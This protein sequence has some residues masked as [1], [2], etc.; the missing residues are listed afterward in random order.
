[1]GDNVKTATA[2]SPSERGA[3]CRRYVVRAHNDSRTGVWWADSDDLPGLVSEAPSYDELVD[4]V[5]AVFPDLC[6][7]SDIAI[8][9]GDVLQIRPLGGPPAMT[10][11]EFDRALSKLGERMWEALNNDDFVVDLLHDL[12][13]AKLTFDGVERA[14][15]ELGAEVAEAIFNER[16]PDHPEIVRPKQFVQSR[17]WMKNSIYNLALRWVL[18]QALARMTVERT[19][20][21]EVGKFGP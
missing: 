14:E 11:E 20:A 12:A 13:D 4:R 9:D 1:M 5:A 16:D 6:R 2:V 18:D 17:E 7:A 21:S 19:F 8:H 15:S 3:T 10:K